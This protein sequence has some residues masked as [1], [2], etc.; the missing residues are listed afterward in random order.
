MEPAQCV[1]NEGEEANAEGAVSAAVL[2][3]LGACTVMEG[4]WLDL[5]LS[6]M[7]VGSAYVEHSVVA[8]DAPVAVNEHIPL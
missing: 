3:V 7:R 6:V 5:S 8:E 1:N 2:V 4:S